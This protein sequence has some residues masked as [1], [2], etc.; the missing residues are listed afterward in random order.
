VLAA[1]PPRHDVV[2]SQVIIR[3]AAV[4]ANI[5]VAIKNL[6]LSQFPLLPWTLDKIT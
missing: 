2:Q 3:T 4:L 1:S 6:E 5:L